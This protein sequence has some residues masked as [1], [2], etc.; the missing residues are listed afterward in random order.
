MVSL[1]HQ[2]EMMAEAIIIVKWI[3]K[4]IKS[5]QW[6]VVSSKY[7][8][9]LK[10]INL[11]RIMSFRRGFFE[12]HLT[13]I[14]WWNLIFSIASRECYNKTSASDLSSSSSSFLS[15]LYLYFEQEKKRKFHHLI[16]AHELTC[17]QNK[18]RTFNFY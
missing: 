15:T 14:S 4:F 5:E 12:E 10:L 1:L 11:I 9:S 16:N 17:I 7:H 18:R 13:F 2:L 6:T 8:K 3:N